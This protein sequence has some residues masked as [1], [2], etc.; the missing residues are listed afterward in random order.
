[1]ISDNI[2]VDTVDIIMTNPDTSIHQYFM[3]K[4]DTLYYLN[5]SYH[6]IGE[7]AFTILVN[8]T[9]QN[10]C[11]SSLYQIE[12]VQNLPPVSDPNGPYCGEFLDSV[13]FDGSMSYD[14]DGMIVNYTWD[15]GDGSVGYGMVIDHVYGATG[16][17]YVNL[18]VTD[19]QG[20]ID[21][22][23]TT[24]LISDDVIDQIQEHMKYQFPIFSMNILAQSFKPTLSSLT[25]IDLY[26]S[27]QA[28]TSN[29]LLISIRDN[30]YGPNLCTIPLSVSDIGIQMDWITVDIPDMEVTA[31][32]TYFIVVSTMYECSS[33]EGFYWGGSDDG[34]YSDGSLWF[35]IHSW[36]YW[37]KL[38]YLDSCF[39]TYGT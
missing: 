18:T 13:S 12:I 24:V 20:A 1:L 11:I 16:I 17:F 36:Q 9:S 32:D 38:Y 37:M 31:G 23:M 39:R 35:Y 28:S 6:L 2:L 27:R 19:D 5:I 22:N 14:V 26:L 33:D 4:S 3:M 21:C 30:R 25:K 15:F 8:D 29:V 34:G 10:Q 7:Y